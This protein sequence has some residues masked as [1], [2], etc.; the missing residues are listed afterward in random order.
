LWIQF[1]ICSD[2][3][4]DDFP[5]QASFSIKKSGSITA[6]LSSIVLYLRP[7]RYIVM[8]N[9]FVYLRRSDCPYSTDTLAV[10]I[11]GGF[12]II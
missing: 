9:R 11:A 12:E 7:E 6:G 8:Q 3:L 1:S 10:G 4:F 5:F 2:S